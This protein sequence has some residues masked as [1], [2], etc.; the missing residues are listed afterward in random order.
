M[1]S[2]HYMLPGEFAVLLGMMLAPALVLGLAAQSLFLRI[3]WRVGFQRIGASVG[4]TATVSMIIVLTAGWGLPGPLR[5]VLAI[6]GVWLG[7]MWVPV[8]PFCYVAVAAVAVM[9]SVLVRPRAENRET[10]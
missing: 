10:H 4:L 1:Q 2:A 5:G 6:R 8:M 7:E 3:R 9:V